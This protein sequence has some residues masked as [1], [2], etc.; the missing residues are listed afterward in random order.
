MSR[1]AKTP[2]GQPSTGVLA[3][4]G[5]QTAPAYFTLKPR[6]A[7]VAAVF[8]AVLAIVVRTR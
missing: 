1:T 3:M 2:V 6:Q 8:V 4:D 7:V 5:R